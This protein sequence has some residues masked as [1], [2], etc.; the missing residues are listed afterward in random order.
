VIF[1]ILQYD[2]EF[3][4]FSVDKNKMKE[5]EGFETLLSSL[6]NIDQRS[7]VITYTD[8]HGDLLPINNNDNFQKALSTAKPLL[9]V[10]IQMKGDY[11]LF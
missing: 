5:Y 9:R 1:V 4:R 3:R 11:F 2:A 10:M 8:I 6:H 7:F